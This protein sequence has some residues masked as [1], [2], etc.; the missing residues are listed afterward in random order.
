MCNFYSTYLF[1]HLFIEPR[2]PMI[3]C[4]EKKYNHIVIYDQIYLFFFSENNY[5]FQI[6]RW[7]LIIKCASSFFNRSSSLVPNVGMKES[8][9]TPCLLRLDVRKIAYSYRIKIS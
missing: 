6:K 4:R 2:M 7:L 3:K 8:S 1:I 5:Y 9:R